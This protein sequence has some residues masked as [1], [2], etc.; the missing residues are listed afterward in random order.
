MIT[1]HPKA[2][3]GHSKTGWLDS[4]HTFS[5]GSF[6]DPKRMGFGN[7]RVLNEDTI[8]PGSGFAE[9]RH[10]G[11]DILTY[12]T[13]GQLRHSDNQGNVS[14]ISAGEAQLM[15]A[16]DGVSHSERNAS[17]ADIAQF[18][19][20]WLIP[21]ERAGASSYAQMTVP[22]TGNVMLAGPA[23]SKSLLTLRSQTTVRLVRGHEGSTTRL[24]DTDTC[25]FVQLIDGLAFAE[26]ER[27]SAGDG[28]QM[29]I[30]E[31]TSLDW[32]TPGAL[33][34]FTMPNERRNM[35]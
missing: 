26:S 2:I 33:L 19:Q 11:M 3:R 13:K 30:G 23:S 7:L 29:P 9:H 4:Y 6:Q 14:L 24:A 25:R 21:D 5:F 31:E 17:D 1:I 20:I 35:S 16:G 28:L 10:E 27:L 18:F 8:I 15:A 34:L 32:A 22:D 12:V